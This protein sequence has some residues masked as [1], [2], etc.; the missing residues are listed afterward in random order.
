[1]N[2]INPPTL[3]PCRH[4]LKWAFIE[5]SNLRYNLHWVD[6]P[7]RLSSVLSRIEEIN[8]LFGSDH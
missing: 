6:D 1:M 3:D 4:A 7:R 2:R 5:R 8:Q